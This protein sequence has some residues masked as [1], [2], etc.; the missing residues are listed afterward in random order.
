MY[1]DEERSY[2]VSDG[3]GKILGCITIHVADG[4]Q[5]YPPDSL[6]DTTSCP[7]GTPKTS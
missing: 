4:S 3:E 2:V 1:A 5:P 6:S 7:P